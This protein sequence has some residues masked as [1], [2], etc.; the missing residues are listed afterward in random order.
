MQHIAGCIV[1]ASAKSRYALIVKD[2]S[3]RHIFEQKYG[4]EGTGT[5]VFKALARTRISLLV[6]RNLGNLNC[7]FLNIFWAAKFYSAASFWI[8]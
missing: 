4:S 3:K 7:N 5:V 1:T 8:S 6:V 2:R